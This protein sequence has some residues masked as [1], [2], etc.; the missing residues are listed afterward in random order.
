MKNAQLVAAYGHL[1]RNLDIEF[2]KF[3]GLKEASHN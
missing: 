1:F 2:P 3:I